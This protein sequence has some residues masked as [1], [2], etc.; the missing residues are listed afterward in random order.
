MKSLN[1][2]VAATTLIIC[3]A[4][5]QAQNAPV[6]TDSFSVGGSAQAQK[7]N[8]PQSAVVRYSA[9]DS[10]P[11]GFVPV[12]QKNQPAAVQSPAATHYS[13]G[14]SIL[15]GALPA[16]PSNIAAQT[17]AAK[18]ATQS[19]LVIR[20]SAG[21]SIP[22]GHPTAQQ[23]R[24]LASVEKRSKGYSGAAGIPLAGALGDSVTTHIGISQ[25]GLTESNGFIHTSPAGLVGLFV[26]KAGM[27]YYFDN[28]K[29]EVR[30]MGL[31]TSAGVWSGVTMNN[32]LLIAG[33]TNPV[34]LV[35]GALFGAYMYYREGI[36][37]DKESAAK[38]AQGL[39]AQTR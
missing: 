17:A 10:I 15:L 6:G 14:D 36:A 2:L 24:L 27:V 30:K 19:D 12:A 7:N 4:T 37:L 39:H 28:Q 33:S 25:A 34:S 16:A 21:D 8:P 18:P 38:A 31:K 29:P 11:L 26:I 20:Y 35:G 13:A 9:G 23:E 3:G 1:N 5:A 22:V 32:L